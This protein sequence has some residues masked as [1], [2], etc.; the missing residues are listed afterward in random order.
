M[1]KKMGRPTDS[2]KDISLRIRINAQTDEKLKECSQTLD[3]TKS[4]V[5]R[6]GINR[7]HD[8]LKNKK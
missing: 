3:V 6:Q 2:P 1:P 4:E 7:I 5:V 8:D